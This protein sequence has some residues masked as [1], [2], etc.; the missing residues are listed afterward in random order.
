NA[1]MKNR[2]GF[3]RYLTEFALKFKPPL[4]FFRNFV[5]E[6]KGEHRDAFDIKSAMMPI[7][8][9]ARVY[10]LKNGVEAT[11]TL[12][13]LHQLCIKEILTQEEYDEL[14]KAYSFM[15]Q[16]RFTRQVTVAKDRERKLDNF[17]NPKR[18]TRIEQ[19]MLKEIFKRIEKF[20]TKM[21]FDFIGIA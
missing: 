18:L 9:F 13:R 21:N 17:I 15:M 1:V 20:Q 16:L 3:L 12:D 11:N 10:A 6:S 14:E 5:V 4:G 19:T 2:S 7:V 8:G